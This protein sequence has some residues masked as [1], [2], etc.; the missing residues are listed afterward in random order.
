MFVAIVMPMAALQ[1]V[2]CSNQ[3][4]KD[5]FTSIDH[6]AAGQQPIGK[7]FTNSLSDLIAP[8]TYICTEISG[9]NTINFAI[10]GVGYWGPNYVRL[11][12][13]TK[14]V[15]L[16]SVC[17]LKQANLDKI[18]SSFPSV[19]TTT[20]LDEVVNDEAIDAVIVCTPLKSHFGIVKKMLEARKHVLC[21][22]PMTYT[23]S[24]SKELIDIA[25]KNGVK[26]AVGQIFEYNSCV[27]YTK[28]M[29][30]EKVLGDVMYLHFKRTGLGPIRQD[31]NAMWDLASH[32]ISIALN[33]L[34]TNPIS[35][36]AFGQ[37]YIQQ[38][39]EDVVFINLEFPDKVIAN[40]HVSWLDP[41]KVRTAT[42]VGTQKM[43]VFD[44]LSL[45]EKIRIYD[46]G[47]SYQ[48]ASFEF[49]EF[50]LSLRDG[51]ISIP[52]VKYDEPLKTEVYDFI[53][54]VVKMR[55]PYT[56]GMK[57]FNVVRVLEA[58]Q[59]SLENQNQKVNLN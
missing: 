37:T 57:G 44:D 47:A 45:S 54:S 59:Y 42:V 2:Q 4:L 52:N 28:R 7:S 17:D 41:C 31:I 46:K 39:V 33:L 22:K 26:L 35:V 56:N 18:Q 20:N 9:M 5:C 25:E 21:E 24:E 32:D 38:G 36:C 58:C 8:L 29:I 55:E 19:H 40:I 48:P 1:L 11:L 53:D 12:S 6:V 13:N 27:Q 16:R 14:N 50:Q 3:P 23:S 15:S 43:L 49:S 51:G 34:E 30:D 10:V